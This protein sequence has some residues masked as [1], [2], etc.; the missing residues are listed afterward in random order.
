MSKDFED[1]EPNAPLEEQ[2]SNESADQ[3]P[4]DESRR[5]FLTNLGKWSGAA[6]GIALLG[7]AVSSTD[8]EAAADSD[9]KPEESWRCWR[10]YRCYRCRCRC[11]CW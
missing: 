4:Q 7:T 9:Q 1:K 10:C 6:I 3:G 8:S 11:R 2:S 5:R